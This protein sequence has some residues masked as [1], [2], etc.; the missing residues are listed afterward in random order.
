MAL[1][2]RKFKR[3]PFNQG[4]GVTGKLSL[5]K[6]ED[7]FVHADISN[8]SSS[9]VGLSFKADAPTGINTGDQI[10]IE[11]ITGIKYLNTVSKIKAKSVPWVEIRGYRNYS[12]GVAQLG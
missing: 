1:E 4:V 9:G 8:L 3:L 11:E 10:L 7:H 5:P 2:N 6:I 12:R